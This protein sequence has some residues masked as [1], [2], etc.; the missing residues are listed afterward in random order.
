MMFVSPLWVQRGDRQ[1][2]VDVVSIKAPTL[3]RVGELVR[4][5]TSGVEIE[6]VG[7]LLFVGLR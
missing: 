3:P 2:P 1:A 4:I 5:R 6:A 7:R